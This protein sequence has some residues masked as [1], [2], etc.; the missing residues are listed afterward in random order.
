MTKIHNM[1]RDKKEKE[2]CLTRK[3]RYPK[4]MQ[5]SIPIRLQHEELPLSNTNL[6]AWSCLYS[7]I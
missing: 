6:D 3:P 1:M 4:Q 5:F 7:T 2:I